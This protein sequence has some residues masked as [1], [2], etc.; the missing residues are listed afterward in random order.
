MS[1]HKWVVN[2]AKTEA[3][4]LEVNEGVHS[5]NRMEAVVRF[6]G[7]VHLYGCDADG[8]REDYMHICDLDRFIELVMDLKTKAQKHFGKEWPK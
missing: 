3:H 4:W 6:D 8:K 1:K 2:E 5:S 7:C